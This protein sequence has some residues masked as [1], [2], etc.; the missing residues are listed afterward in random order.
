MVI[1]FILYLDFK[2]KNYIRFLID[3][4]IAFY[5]KFVLIRRETKG[6]YKMK[7]NKV[8][9]LG[10][11]IVAFTV[12]GLA[13]AAATN[14]GGIA[15]GLKTQATQITVLVSAAS[16]LIGAA[17]CVKAAL[18]FKKYS[19]DQG[20]TPLSQ[21][22]IYAAVGACLLAFPAFTGVGIGTI[23]GTTAGQGTSAGADDVVQG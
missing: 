18:E 14:V 15:S 16:Y 17:V 19:T 6:V 9:K 23:F 4:L 11:G 13:L 22:C 7:L 2:K 12:P 3:F 20:R 10:L 8:E 21:P 5:F 1:F